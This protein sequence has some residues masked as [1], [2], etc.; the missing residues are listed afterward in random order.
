MFTPVLT[1]KNGDQLI[2]NTRSGGGVPDRMQVRANFNDESTD[3]GAGVNG[4]GKFTTTLLDINPG[5][6]A[7]TYPTLWTRYVI[8]FSGLTGVKK[9]R[10]AFRYYIPS[11]AGDSGNNADVIGVDSCAFV[12]N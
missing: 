2:F 5:L 8:N 4:T 11:D 3:V 7:G 12:S 10:I 9:G 6:A 1:V